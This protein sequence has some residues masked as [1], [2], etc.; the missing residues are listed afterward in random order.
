LLARLDTVLD[1]A[2]GGAGVPE[3]QRTL[4][5]AIEWSFRLLSPD[6]QRLLAWL[7]VFAGG[8]DIDAVTA[9]APADLGSDPVD[10]LLALVEASFVVPR[11]DV[12][13][14]RFEL[15]ETMRRFA[16]EHL[17]HLGETRAARQAH[18]QHFGAWVVGLRDRAR[19]GDAV[20]AELAAELFN[21]HELLGREHEPVS[22]PTE[23]ASLTPL[24]L[25]SFA[26]GLAINARQI[27]T[28]LAWTESTRTEPG[29]TEDPLGYLACCLERAAALSYSDSAACRS[30]LRAVLGELPATR[31][32]ADDRAALAAAFSPD[33]LEA[34]T[35]TY[36]SVVLVTLDLFDE[37]EAYGRQALTLPGLAHTERSK[38]LTALSQVALAQD[39]FVQARRLIIELRELDQAAGDTWR[40]VSDEILLA[41]VEVRMNTPDRAH[42]RLAAVLPRVRQLGDVVLTIELASILAAALGPT[43]P[44]PAART[45]GAIETA[46]RA[47]GM[48]DQE[49][50]WTQAEH[51]RLRERLGP[52]FDEELARGSALSLEEAIDELMSHPVPD[53]S[54]D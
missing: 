6:Q 24:Q 16:R 34:R 10:V 26:A 2:A 54:V 52:L 14:P 7:S 49:P 36:L 35:M 17:D 29:R 48:V 51:D 5:G 15:L 9:V 44:A 42:A 41:D 27:A 40:L 25:R 11:Y 19:A 21:L 28:A 30:V 38:L 32:A 3:R 50:D 47:A 18:T 8:A 13:P 33:F 1:V 20:A 45:F 23:D 37:A 22:H 31:T 39:D 43:L 4:R 46:T 53:V 12:D